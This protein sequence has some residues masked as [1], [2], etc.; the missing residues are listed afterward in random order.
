MSGAMLNSKR[1]KTWMLRD[2]L[3]ML[4]LG[5]CSSDWWNSD[6]FIQYRYSSETQNSKSSLAISQARPTRQVV[7]T[8]TI[9]KFFQLNTFLVRLDL[10]VWG[11]PIKLLDVLTSRND[12]TIDRH[13]YG[14]SWCLFDFDTRTQNSLVYCRTPRWNV[15]AHLGSVVPRHD[16]KP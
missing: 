8:I 1:N 4:R 10:L 6:I 9:G 11:L 5:S 3:S 12:P 16:W 2:L 14:R 13:P 15:S 7:L